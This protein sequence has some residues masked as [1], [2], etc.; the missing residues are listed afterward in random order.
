MNDQLKTSFE[1]CGFRLTPSEHLLVTNGSPVPLSPKAFEILVLFI[2]N[3]GELI[4]KQDIMQTVWPES[5]VEE[6]NIQVHISAIR[7]ALGNPELI[8]TVPKKGYRFKGHVEKVDIEPIRSVVALTPAD[9]DDSTT[10]QESE[11]AAGSR[12]YITRGRHGQRLLVFLF[13]MIVLSVLIVLGVVERSRISAIFHRQANFDLS[14]LDVR[15]V[16]DNGSS[17][18]AALSP[19]G[20]FLVYQ[21]LDRDKFSV[22]L[23]EPATG[24]RVQIVTPGDQ[25]RSGFVFSPGG[26]Q[27]YFISSDRQAGSVSN[28]YRMPR[29]GGDPV[30]ILE[31]LDSAVSFSPDGSEFAFIRNDKTAGESSLMISS[32]AGDSVRSIASRKLPNLYPTGKRPAWSPDGRSI[33]VIG[34]N[35]DEKFLRVLLVDIGDRSERPLSNEN[36]SAVQDVAWLANSNKL[37]VTAQDDINFGPLQLW[38]VSTLDGTAEKVSRELQSYVGLS[39]D[40]NASTLVSTRNEAFQNIWVQQGKDFPSAKQI[41]SNK[42]SGRVD[43]SWTHDGHILYT[44]NT[45]GHSNIFLIDADGSNATQLTNDI[46]EKRSPIASPDRKYIVFV[47]SQTGPE[48][49]WRMNPDGSSQRQLTSTKTF[50]SP[51]ISLD[52]KWVIFLTW[53]DGKA[54]IWKTSID[55]SEPI[56]LKSDLSFVPKISHDLGMI[57]FADKTVENQNMTLTVIR[58]SDGSIVSTF[59]LPAGTYTNSVEWTPDDKAVL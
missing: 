13:G 59:K 10:K 54:S 34:R 36:W 43:L 55:G 14:Q 18:D 33:A 56:L 26:D 20:K 50:L 9:T 51:Q 17:F 49:V 30:K 22:W 29:L 7:K 37:L 27:L 57:A 38:K 53:S 2:E 19:D 4:T 31:Q 25:R 44:S 48:Q 47:S 45:D 35:T 23:M 15:R 41:I 39:V 24:S 12:K 52:G 28:L 16:T 11:H 58:F 3:P 8:E 21:T 42:G 32:I 1:F 6:S 40:Q 46:F 5:Y